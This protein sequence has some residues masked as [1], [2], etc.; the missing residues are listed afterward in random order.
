MYFV[1]EK[2]VKY[3]LT[4]YNNNIIINFAI[5]RSILRIPNESLIT[6]QSIH[7]IPFYC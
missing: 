3:N 4:C 1:V 2:S 5:W 6:I 7:T